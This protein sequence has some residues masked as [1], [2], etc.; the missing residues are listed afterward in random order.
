MSQILSHPGASQDALQAP[1]AY[2]DEFRLDAGLTAG[3]QQVRRM[4]AII[5]K[6]LWTEGIAQTDQLTA[7]SISHYLGGLREEGRSEK[8]VL[9]HRT[10]LSR[11]CQFLVRP[12]GA[13]DHNLVLDVRVRQPEEKL[14]RYLEP[15]EIAIVLML[16]QR[17]GIWPEIVLALST[18]LRLGEMIR[19]HWSDIDLQRRTVAVRISK[20]RRPRVVP[21]SA[22]A[23]D[24]LRVQRGK[25]GSMVYVF[26]A[27]QTFP[28]GWRYIDKARASSWWG[29]AIRPI[30]DAVPKFRELPGR[31]T[32]RGWHLLRHT[33][34]S[35]AAQAGVSLYKIAAWMGHSDVRTTRIYAHLQAG[36][37]EDIEHA[38]PAK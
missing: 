22:P 12:I 11:F 31:S 32:G 4:I 3:P 2:L 35:R 5:R 9:N 6:F 8:T 20:S 18:G 7:R 33:F 30:Q 17:N 38:A 37:D 1:L 14:P 13:L 29:R 36:Y 21:L 28:R 23:L 26:P 24:A 10:A 27:R 25:S 19:L 16:A 34:G 15:E